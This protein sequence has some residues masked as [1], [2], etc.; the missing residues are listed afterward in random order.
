MH[1]RQRDAAPSVIEI[2]VSSIAQS[3]GIVLVDG[4]VDVEA[5]HR[6]LSPALSKDEIDS[7]IQ[8]WKRG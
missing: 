7:L 1:V 8:D 3:F 6:G 2:D 4:E 5:T